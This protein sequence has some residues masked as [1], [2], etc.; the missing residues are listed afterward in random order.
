MIGFPN[1]PMSWIKK[2]GEVKMLGVK[3]REEG[4]A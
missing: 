3:L 1:P 4:S 2:L